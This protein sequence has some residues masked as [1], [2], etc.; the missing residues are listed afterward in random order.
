MKG[1]RL[2]W[3]ALVVAIVAAVFSGLQ[4]LETRELRQLTF[5]AAL[6]FEIN[7]L[8]GKHRL[9]IGVRNAGPGVARI[10]TVTFYLDGKLA[11]DMVDTLETAG[12]DTDRDEGIELDRGDFLAPNEIVWLIDYRPKSREDGQRASALIENRVQVAI[13]YCATTGACTRICSDSAGC[14]VQQSPRR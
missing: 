1:V 13:D 9:G 7:T 5:G 12:F 3:I 11:D 8:A 2:D 10:Q 6:S 14:P 4:W